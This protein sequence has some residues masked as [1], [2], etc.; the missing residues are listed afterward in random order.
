MLNISKCNVQALLN[1]LFPLL[2][3]PLLF[4]FDPPPA[5]LFVA[6][7]PLFF[8]LQGQ[9]LR[10]VVD[11]DNLVDLLDLFFSFGEIASAEIFLSFCVMLVRPRRFFGILTFLFL[12]DFLLGSLDSVGLFLFLCSDEV[13][14]SA[15]GMTL[16]GFGGLGKTRNGV[17]EE[18]VDFYRF[19]NVFQ[20]Y[21]SHSVRTDRQ[22]VLDLIVDFG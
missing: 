15:R 14:F 3:L 18:L 2:L 11:L 9:H 22:L 17:E 16:C 21:R 12:V 20:V 10:F 13:G 5:F 4:F 19:S 6:H 7:C 1:L 8:N